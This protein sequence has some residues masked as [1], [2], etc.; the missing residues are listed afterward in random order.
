LLTS[1]SKSSM[2]VAARRRKVSKARRQAERA[3]D[4]AWC[5]MWIGR[6]SG[7][8]RFPLMTAPGWPA[9]VKAT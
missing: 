9:N 3:P 1:W 6:P 2:L 7:E 4:P 5:L 8:C